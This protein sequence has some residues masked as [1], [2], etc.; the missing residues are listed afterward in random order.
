MLLENFYTEEEKQ[1]FKEEY[2]KNVEL[3]KDIPKVSVVTNNVLP[4]LR[5]G[6]GL[7]NYC[8]MGCQHCINTF[9]EGEHKEIDS[10]FFGD[11]LYQ[12]KDLYKNS[13]YDKM[14]E[15]ILIF[16]FFNYDPLLH[17]NLKNLFE[18]NH[19]IVT[20][21]KF[22]FIIRTN[23][24]LITKSHINFFE[25]MG[26]LEVHVDC[27]TKK[28]YDTVVNFFRTHNKD[29]IDMNI[30]IR[31]E[32]RLID[33]GGKC[34]FKIFHYVN[35]VKNGNFH[36]FN[37]KEDAT[38]FHK[39]YVLNPPENIVP[40]RICSYPF[41]RMYITCDK[42]VVICCNSFL[43]EYSSIMGDLEKNTLY[44]IWNGDRYYEMRKKFLEENYEKCKKCLLLY[45]ESS[46]IKGTMWRGNSFLKK[47]LKELY[48]IKE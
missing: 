31:E 47:Q 42:K 16:L 7:V 21:T 41:E 8:T 40:N 15:S 39:R 20:D 11:L 32:K 25:P 18:E 24:K 1:F 44:E 35:P 3:A 33:N 14:G 22:R 13:I 6:I 45:D 5:V 26:N 30:N 43:S 9:V 34:T 46:V 10:A 23:G 27:Y 17:K 38:I 29:Y 4:P 28:D 36:I 48:Q 19:S 37:F 12:I 2:R